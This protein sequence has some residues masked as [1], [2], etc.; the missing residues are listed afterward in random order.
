M[1][2][3]HLYFDLSFTSE[4]VVAPN[5]T[6]DSDEDD[7]DMTD[8][9]N[10]IQDSQQD[11]EGVYDN[12][13][14]ITVGGH[15][16]CIQIVLFLYLLSCKA[17]RL[18]LKPKKNT[19]TSYQGIAT[20][21]QQKVNPFKVSFTLQHQLVFHGIMVNLPEIGINIYYLKYIRIPVAQPVYRGKVVRYLIRSTQ[22]RN[23]YN[24]FPS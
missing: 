3:V 5:R 10:G 12:N 20:G 23:P 22:N 9:E 17:P 21:S 1:N 19:S 6:V 18:L 8:G 4:E 16:A 14:I 24:S 7:I 2:C 13:L 11:E 15:S